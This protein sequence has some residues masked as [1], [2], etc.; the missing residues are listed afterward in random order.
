MKQGDNLVVHIADLGRSAA[1]F[2]RQLKLLR[3]RGFVLHLLDDEGRGFVV[4]G[5]MDQAKLDR[6]NEAI[7]RAAASSKSR[8]IRQTLQK[9]RDAGKPC[10]NRPPFGFCV[11]QMPTD[12]VLAACKHER[13]WAPMIVRWRSEGLT[14]PQVHAELVR[15]RAKTNQGELWSWRRMQRFAEFLNRER[16]S[17][18]EAAEVEPAQPEP[19]CGRDPRRSGSGP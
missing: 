9:N 16:A 5:A 19:N 10:S 4:D 17:W 12:P 2:V 6:L 15:R 7:T 11:L 8:R 1:D 13:H 14:W 3:N 18:L